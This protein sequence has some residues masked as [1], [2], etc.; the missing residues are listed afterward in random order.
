MRALAAV[1]R[2]Q[3]LAETVFL[4]VNECDLPLFYQGGSVDGGI[5]ASWLQ[6]IL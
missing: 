3:P 4:V 1:K 2:L 5:L 6:G